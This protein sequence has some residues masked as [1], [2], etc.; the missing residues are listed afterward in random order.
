M[1][2]YIEPLSFLGASLTIF[3]AGIY[4]IVFEYLKEDDEKTYLFGGILTVIG[5]IML[6]SGFIALIK[7]QVEFKDL[8][9][10]KEK[11][12]QEIIE[13]LEQMIVNS[14][15]FQSKEVLVLK[16]ILN[17]KRED[18]KL[19]RKQSKISRPLL[20][21]LVAFVFCFLAYGYYMMN[22]I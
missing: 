6:L 11:S 10:S 8:A 15:D 18:L 21:L 3:G 19:L 1:K 7:G 13:D 16:G 5:I 4:F 17:Q 12:L 22:I 9:Q 20:I 14:K 2:K